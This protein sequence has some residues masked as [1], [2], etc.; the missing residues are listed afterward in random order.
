MNTFQ[1]PKSG[2]LRIF[3]NAT[4]TW[5]ALATAGISYVLPTAQPISKYMWL[6]FYLLFN[7]F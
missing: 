1:N 6:M 7:F 4:T 2:V 3:Q 5:K